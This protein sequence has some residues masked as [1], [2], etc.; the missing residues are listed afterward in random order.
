MSGRR[1]WACLFAAAVTFTVAPEAGAQGSLP[2][3]ETDAEARARVAALEKEVVTPPPYE[4]PFAGSDPPGSSSSRTTWSRACRRSPSRAARRLRSRA[5]SWPASTTSSSG[6][7][8]SDS[9]SRPTPRTSSGTAPTAASSGRRRARSP[10]GHGWGSTSPSA[11]ASRSIRATFGIEWAHRDEQT[12]AGSSATIAGS[13]T[14]APDTTQTGPFVLLYVPVLVHPSPHFFLGFGPFIFRD[15]GRD[16]GGPDVG[17]ERTRLGAALELGG[18]LGGTPPPTVATEEVPHPP[19]RRFGQAGEVVIW[20]DVTTS[21][22]WTAYD[23]TS[24]SNT[25]IS[26]SPGVDYFVVDHVAIGVGVSVAYSK[27]SGWMAGSP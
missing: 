18:Y 9:T 24:S 14:G 19:A 23:G 10:A 6:T 11:G 27:V 15:F 2:S 3:F 25:S 16:Q 5:R 20:G 21:A 22:F 1:P 13:P 12:L 4:P 17:A 26:F 7:S 8:P